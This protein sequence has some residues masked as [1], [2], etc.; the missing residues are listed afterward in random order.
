MLNRRAIIEADR[1]LLNKRVVQLSQK[2]R[3]FDRLE[4][5]KETLEKML[6]FNEYRMHFISNMAEGQMATI[7]RGGTFV[8]ISDGPHIP[9]TTMLKAFKVFQVRVD[10]R[11]ASSTLSLLQ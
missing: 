8:D 11:L 7:Y 4:V 3:G 5:S 2:S 6:S 9:S 1:E 10:A